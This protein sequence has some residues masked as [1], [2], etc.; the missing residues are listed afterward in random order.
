MKKT[1]VLI[2]GG[3]AAGIVVA[4]TGKNCYPKK[5]F[6]VIRKEKKVI[7]PC[8]IPYIFGSLDNSE[9]DVIP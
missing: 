7:V 5:S 1:D 8:G 9:K 3:S 2:I 4:I 6:L